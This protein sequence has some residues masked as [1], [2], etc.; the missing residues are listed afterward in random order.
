MMEPQMLPRPP[1]TTYTSTRMEV[2]KSNCAALTL[3]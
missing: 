1:S 2:L 3:A